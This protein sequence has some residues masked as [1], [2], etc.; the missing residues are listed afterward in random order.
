M[1]KVNDLRNMK[2]QNLVTENKIEKSGGMVGKSIY[3]LA[4]SHGSITL[5][6]GML[7][8]LDLH[9]WVGNFGEC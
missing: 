6:V 3:Y 7:G 4:K 5:V 2:R 1:Q 8:L 9:Y